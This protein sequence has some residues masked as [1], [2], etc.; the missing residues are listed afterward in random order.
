MSEFQ[1]IYKIFQN[2]EVAIKN[3]NT[4][5]MINIEGEEDPLSNRSNT[6]PSELEPKL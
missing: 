2:L 1:E 4:N 6:M 3:K 5:N